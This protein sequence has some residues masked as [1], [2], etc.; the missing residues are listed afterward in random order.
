MTSVDLYPYIRTKLTSRELTNSEIDQAFEEIDQV[1]K[2][3]CQISVV[4]DALKFTVCNMMIDLLNY[5]YEVNRNPEETGLGD[6]DIADVTSFKEGDTSIQM[7]QSG[8]TITSMRKKAISSHKPMLD[9]IT[10]NYTKQ[11]NQFRRIW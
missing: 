2:N 11:L 5:E 3:Y 9:E 8:S 6:V 10:M 4:P 1:V 7:G